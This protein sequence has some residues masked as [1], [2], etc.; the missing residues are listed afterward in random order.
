MH[1][2]ILKSSVW[3]HTSSLLGSP[4]SDIFLEIYP[5]TGH[6]SPPLPLPQSTPRCSCL[7]DYNSLLTGSFASTLCP[8][9]NSQHR[10]DAFKMRGRSRHSSAQI[11]Q[12]FPISF[13]VKSSLYYASYVLDSY[14][15]FG[16]IAHSL[17]QAILVFSAVSWTGQAH[18]PSR[19]W[20]GGPL[21]YPTLIYTRHPPSLP[22]GFC[23]TFTLSVRLSPDYLL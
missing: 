15:L 21:S 11:L 4:I 20:T 5:E 18:P 23:P 17:H 1:G 2:V 22:L 13:H 3:H 9:V 19:P 8:L 16:L 6:F 7:E 10:K 12:C 14:D